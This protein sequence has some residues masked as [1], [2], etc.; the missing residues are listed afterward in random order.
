MNDVSIVRG[1]A[2]SNSEYVSNQMKQFGV[3][4]A[5]INKELT[6]IFNSETLRDMNHTIRM[7]SV[8]QLGAGFDVD[9][10]G[11]DWVP[12][13]W[14]SKNV[15]TLIDKEARFMFASPPSIAVRDGN[16]S[17]DSPNNKNRIQPN[18]DF[19]M[20]V[21]NNNKINNKL[22][23]AAKDC[24]IGKR[25]AI[26]VNFNE[27]TGITVSFIPSLEFVYETDPTDVDTI[28]KFIQFYNVTVNEEKSQQRIYKKKWYMT[29]DNICHVVEELYDGNANLIETIV[30]DTATRLSYIPVEIV[31][32]DGLSGDPFGESE[33]ETLVD[34]E[35][36]I[37]KLSSKDID[38]L[39]KGTDQIV[40]ARDI[41]PRT[42]KGLSRA[43]GAFWDLQTDPAKENSVGAVGTLDNS[44]AYSGALDTTLNRL[45]TSMYAALDVPDTSN[46][47]LQGIVTSGKTM[48]AIYWGLMVRCDEKMLSWIPALETTMYTIIEGAKLYP[49]VRK[50][51]QEE[52]LV[53]DYIITVEN[54]YPILQDVTEEKSADI[55]EVNAKV[56]S[57]KSYMKK[58]RGL[59][60]EEINSELEQILKEQQMLE[61][62][63]FLG[64][65][66]TGIIEEE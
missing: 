26:A 60:D 64:S 42:T 22:V 1:F 3:T 61:N 32:N 29:E 17:D 66:G 7:Y 11:N 36:I 23:K 47:A 4:R 37:S 65:G 35:S 55:L 50:L 12:T 62:D 45:K 13:I 8:Y 57:R 5:L 59:T 25:I 20:S 28:T 19:L 46:E 38:S 39:R 16:N 6:G 31:I 56:L 53:D 51:Y 24:L 18:E 52:E 33:V 10:N 40:W 34:T 21:L 54:N 14:K 63:N 41:D 48:Q 58:W 44:M 27:T 43:A 49:E 2:G 30:P 9:V 15:K